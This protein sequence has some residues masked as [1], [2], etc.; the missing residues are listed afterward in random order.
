MQFMPKSHKIYKRESQK[1][2][3]FQENI[4]LYRKTIGIVI[5]VASIIVVI[6][7]VLGSISLSNINIGT[8]FDPLPVYKNGFGVINGY[9]IGTSKISTIGTLMVAM[10]QRDD[11]TSI[12][13]GVESDGKYVFEDLKPGKYI[14]IAYFP[15]GKYKVMNNIQVQSNSVQSLNF[16][17]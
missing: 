7:F 12:L 17:Y 14:I 3:S 15:D 2:L 8:I 4:K 13:A 11:F 1:Q 6:G 10:E 16:K 5:A 9:V